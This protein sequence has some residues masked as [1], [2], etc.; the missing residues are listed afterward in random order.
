MVYKTKTHKKTNHKIIFKRKEKERRGR[1][2][3]VE[4]GEERGEGEAE[5]RGGEMK[6]YLGELKREE[7]KKKTP[8]NKLRHT[9]IYK[10]SP[11]M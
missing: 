3:G 6:C 1:G 2:G 7:G 11:G 8:S 5:G 10:I 9:S 4:K